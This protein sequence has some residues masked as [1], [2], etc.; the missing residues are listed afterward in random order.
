M[1]LLNTAD[2]I[3]KV[4]NSFEALLTHS[5]LLNLNPSNLLAAINPTG[6][7]PKKLNLYI[8]FCLTVCDICL[9]FTQPAF[10]IY[11]N[12]RLHPVHWKFLW[13]VYVLFTDE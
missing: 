2:S 1:L 11:W 3:I 13:S 7:K 6:T 9:Y 8:D 5:T 10:E 12:G 4:T